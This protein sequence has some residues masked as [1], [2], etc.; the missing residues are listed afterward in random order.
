[1]TIDL[2]ERIIIAS[3]SEAEKLELLDKGDEYLKILSKD[4]SL[5]IRI[6]AKV[7]MKESDEDTEKRRRADFVYLEEEAKSSDF[8]R[9]IKAKMLLRRFRDQQRF[10]T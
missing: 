3:K 4:D 5:A 2:F 10:L 7:R 1:M 6:R 8:S 9:R